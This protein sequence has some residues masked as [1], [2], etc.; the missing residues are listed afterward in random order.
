MNFSLD[1]ALEE[2][3]H[4]ALQLLWQIRLDQQ[5]AFEPLGV[6]PMQ[7]FAMFSIA[8]GVDQPSG[9]ALVLDASPPGVSQLLSGLEERGW[10]RRELDPDNK[11]RVRILLTPQGKSVLEQM[12]LRWREVSRERYARLSPEEIGML[13]QSYRKLLAQAVET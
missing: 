2:F 3:E 10:L 5:R 12:H 9:L 6:S 1:A 8:Q 7:G 4:L 13:T 11:R